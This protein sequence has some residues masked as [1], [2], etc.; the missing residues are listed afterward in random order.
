[1][2]L[3]TKL[4]TLRK[5]NGFTQLDLA[6]R[7]NVSRQAVSRWESGAAIPSTDNLK[8]LSSL[9]GV[10]L[11]YLLNDDYNDPYKK[12]KEKE[13]EPEEQGQESTKQHSKVA[14]KKHIIILSCL[15]IL[16]VS[17][18]VIMG[19]AQAREAEQQ[20]IIPIEEM[21]TAIEDDYPE[22]TFSIE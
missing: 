12:T 3:H 4:V 21:D 14:T 5:Q 8:V 6:A 9:Y 18:A 19:V 2:S 10:S 20:Q 16:V 1:M 11:D 22:G 7:L 13:Q 15:L 17:I